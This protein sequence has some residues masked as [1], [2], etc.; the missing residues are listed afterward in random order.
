MERKSTKRTL[1]STLTLLF[2]KN[3]L[4]RVIRTN[5]KTKQ[6]IEDLDSEMKLVEIAQKHDVNPSYVSNI[7]RD[8]DKKRKL[9]ERDLLISLIERG[10]FIVKRE[11]ITD[12]ESRK[13]E[14]IEP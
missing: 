10:A 3:V 5:A 1:T 12:E 6:I 7:K 8:I 11:L 4:W 14:A 2:A 9:K 13:L